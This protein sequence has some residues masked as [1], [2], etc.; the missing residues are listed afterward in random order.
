MRQ[1]YQSGPVIDRELALGNAALV[2]YLPIGFPT[3]KQSIKSAQVMLENGVDII[4]LGFPYTDPAMDGPVIQQATTVALE[5]DTHLE[6]LLDAVE[7][8]SVSA[9]ILSM[10][11]WNPVHWYGVDRFA[12]AF[13]V[14]AGAG[15]I[16]PDLP[17][18][19]AAQWIEA[20]DKYDLERVFLAAPSSSTER[21]KKIAASSQGWV[22]AAS[23]MGVTGQRASVDV[24]TRDLVQ[25]CRDAGAKRVCVG[26][27]VSNGQQARDIADYADGVIVGSA[28]IKPLLSEPFERAILRIAD[29]AQELKAGVTRTK[30]KA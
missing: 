11:Y 13:S 16:T 24:R 5:R 23:T 9:P 12:Q 19:E 14:A 20:S 15:L 29:L 17:P 4:E 22:Y 2:G 18:E 1:Q 26:L 27:G 21:L 10:T 25:R 28:F 30:V 6:D 8:L 7:I 3:V